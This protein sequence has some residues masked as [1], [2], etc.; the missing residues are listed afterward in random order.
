MEKGT[1]MGLWLL[2]TLLNQWSCKS[3]L[4]DSISVMWCMLVPG[5]PPLTVSLAP[6]AGGWCVGSTQ[7]RA[8]GCGRSWGLR[9]TAR[10][11]SVTTL[12]WGLSPLRQTF[13]F[14]GWWRYVDSVHRHLLW[15]TK[16]QLLCCLSTRGIQSCWRLG[17]RCL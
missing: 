9:H 8:P 17:S 16:S 7:G 1:K 13:G 15:R 14:L 12:P 3:T 11:G 6:V 10:P 5:F 4:L 2:A